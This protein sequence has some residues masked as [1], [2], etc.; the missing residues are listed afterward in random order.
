M[1]FIPRNYYNRHNLMTNNN[2][3]KECKSPWL[4]KRKIRPNNNN[5]NPI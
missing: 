1:K 2:S 4:L 5:T 3:N